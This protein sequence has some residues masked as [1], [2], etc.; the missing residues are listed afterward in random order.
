M[1]GRGWMLSAFLLKTFEENLENFAFGN[2]VGII[3]VVVYGSL[4]INAKSS[5]GIEVDAFLS[6]TVIFSCFLVCFQLH[7]GVLLIL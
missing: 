6:E 1:L 5:D 2:C 3:E 4:L 7:V